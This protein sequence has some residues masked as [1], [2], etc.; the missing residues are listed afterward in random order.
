MRIRPTRD[1]QALEPLARALKADLPEKFF[2]PRNPA[3]A[4]AAQR[5]EAQAEALPPPAAH[6]SETAA[7]AVAVAALLA[8]SVCWPAPGPRLVPRRVQF[9]CRRFLLPGGCSF[10]P[11]KPTHRSDL[12]EELCFP[13][14]RGP[15]SA[16][17][18][19]LLR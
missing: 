16:C 7:V 6:R 11:L 4:A 1:H 10:R 2:A 15:R 8:Q 12:D 14:R 13:L 5:L 19:L 17:S 9:L 18:G 3:V